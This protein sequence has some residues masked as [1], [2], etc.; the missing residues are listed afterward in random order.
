MEKKTPT[1]GLVPVK[2]ISSSVEYIYMTLIMGLT[3]PGVRTLSTTALFY[4]L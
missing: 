4:F 2:F 3:W 1:S